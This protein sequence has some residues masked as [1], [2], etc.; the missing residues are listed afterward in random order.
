MAIGC[1]LVVMAIGCLL[2]VMAIGCLLVV[3]AIGRL[4]RE[5]FKRVRNVFCNKDDVALL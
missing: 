5:T 4:L 1:L 3:M 2:V